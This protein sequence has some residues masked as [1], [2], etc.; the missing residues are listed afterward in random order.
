MKP[1][2]IWLPQ[3]DCRPGA[4]PCRPPTTGGRRTARSPRVFSP[5][6]PGRAADS[7]LLPPSSL[8]LLCAPPRA[9][10]CVRGRRCGFSGPQS[11]CSCP[12]AE[13]PPLTAPGAPAGWRGWAGLR[14]SARPGARPLATANATN[15]VLAA[16][17]PSRPGTGGITNHTREPAHVLGD[18]AAGRGDGSALAVFLGCSREPAAPV[19][20]SR[21]GL[22][23]AVSR[24]RAPATHECVRALGLG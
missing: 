14:V 7:L 10:P 21:R 4:G 18:R 3:G 20:P 15:G 2:V 13:D 5:E 16:A 24:P 6:L 8:F 1:P 23:R 22:G 11:A 17:S 19:P 9:A 12:A